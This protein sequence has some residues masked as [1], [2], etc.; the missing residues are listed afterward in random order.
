MEKKGLWASEKLLQPGSVFRIFL[1]SP[2]SPVALGEEIPATLTAFHRTGRAV[3][4]PTL[5]DLGG[6]LGMGGKQVYKE[7]VTPGSG[8][9]V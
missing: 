1:E 4:V 3:L 9:G 7:L 2:V 8:L 5:R 6:L